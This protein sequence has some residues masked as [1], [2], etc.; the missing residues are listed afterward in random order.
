MTDT[1]RFDLPPKAPPEIVE[2]RQALAER[3]CRVLRLVGLP[4]Y[5]RDLTGD[6]DVR[7]GVDVHVTPFVDGGVF[8]TWRTDA[9][10]DGHSFG[11]M[12]LVTG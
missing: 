1:P 7:P 3:V 8:A 11:T 10:P 2:A 4:V 9:E 5:R 6:P 12:V